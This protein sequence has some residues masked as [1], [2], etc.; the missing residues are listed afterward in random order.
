MYDRITSIRSWT[1]TETCVETCVGHVLHA[2]YT[3]G[4]LLPRLSVSFERHGYRRNIEM[5]SADADMEPS[6]DTDM[7]P[8]ESR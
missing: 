8:S 2:L 6:A 7:E 4:K 3:V 1:S 5:P